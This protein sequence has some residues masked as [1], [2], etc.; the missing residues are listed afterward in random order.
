MKKVLIIED[1]ALVAQIYRSSL[2]KRGYATETCQDGQSGL[3]HVQEHK[4]DAI[5]LDLMLPK[6]NGIDVLV[7][8][9]AQKNLASLPVIVL[10]N[11]YIPDMIQEAFAAGASQVFNK[12]N[13]TPQHILDALDHLLHG[14]KVV[15]SAAPLDV[16]ARPLIPREHPGSPPPPGNY[17]YND[18]Y[19][20]STTSAAKVDDSVFETEVRQAFLKANAGTPAVLRKLVQSIVKAADEKAREPLLVELYRKIHALTGS[21]GVSGFGDIAQMASVLEVLLKEFIEQPKTVNDSTLRTVTFSVDF[22]GELF[23]SSQGVG[24]LPSF[25]VLIVDDESLSRRAVA[26]AL[27]KAHLTFESIDVDDPAVAL[28]LCGGKIFDLIFLDVQMPKIDG[29]E[30]C[31]KIRALP[32]NKS[33]P[34]IFV[35]GLFDFKSRAK[36]TL[37]GGSDLIAKPF[38]FVELALKVMML[39]HRNRLCPKRK[40]A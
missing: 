39:L 40:A 5:L 22:I 25:S 13:I 23:K 16:I 2:E 29:F 9:R 26:Y 4:P 38:L 36:S 33:T 35:T 30:L 37:S 1:D 17:G 15:S 19:T 12:A 7:Q 11:A 27:K 32:A 20:S 24:E 8:M 31:S 3:S 14:G 34:I 10:T 28:R 21:G 6:L 18:N